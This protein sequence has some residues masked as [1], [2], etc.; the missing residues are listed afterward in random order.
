M[1]A[2]IVRRDLCGLTSKNYNNVVLR[3]LQRVRQEASAANL[4]S[5]FNEMD[6]DATALS[7][8]RAGCA[9]LQHA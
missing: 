1:K 8:G 9:H 6:G 7:A 5:L 3:C 4:L 2:Y